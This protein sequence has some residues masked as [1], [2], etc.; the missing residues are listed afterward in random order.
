MIANNNNNNNEIENIIQSFSC[1]ID[2]AKVLSEILG[3][4]SVDYSKAQHCYVE[5]TSDCVYFMI[6]SRLLA[7]CFM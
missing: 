5:A 1:R 2:S 4:L 3:C 6:M 7:S